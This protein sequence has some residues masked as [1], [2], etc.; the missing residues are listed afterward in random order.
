MINGVLNQ[1]SRTC[2]LRVSDAS[3]FQRIWIKGMARQQV[4]AQWH[5]EELME[6]FQTTVLEL[7]QI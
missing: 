7:K 2:A 4:S 3:V 1:S 6:S 5:A